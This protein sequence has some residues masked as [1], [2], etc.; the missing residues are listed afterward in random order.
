MKRVGI[1]NF[2]HRRITGGRRSRA[3][4]KPGSFSGH[5]AVPAREGGH[6]DRPPQSRNSGGQGDHAIHSNELPAHYAAN[7]NPTPGIRTATRNTS[8]SRK[9]STQNSSRIT[10]NWTEAGADHRQ[11]ESHQAND[12]K[13]Q[14]VE[15]R[16]QQQ[17]QQLAQNTNSSSNTYNSNSSTSSRIRIHTRISHMEN[18][19]G[20]AW[21]Y[22][23]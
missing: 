13:M 20:K 19:S 11:L 23:F 2:G 22:A 7:V 15:Q 3:T 10:K 4:E 14:Q 16:H 21:K 9:N 1:R 12:A 18:R 5:D 6:Y 8:S 17:T